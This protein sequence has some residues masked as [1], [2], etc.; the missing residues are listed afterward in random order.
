MF[1][2]RLAT[3]EWPIDRGHCAP[4]S[5]GYLLSGTGIWSF[6]GPGV[7]VQM[8]L[9]WSWL[10]T[11]G[12][13]WTGKSSSG[14]HFGEFHV[15]FLIEGA[16]GWLMNGLM[17]GRGDHYQDGSAYVRIPPHREKM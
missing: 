11:D 1:R 14:F 8:T 6:E 17:F 10:E 12:W 2:L 9:R 3:E 15:D 7:K 13:T 16:G 4:P 5:G